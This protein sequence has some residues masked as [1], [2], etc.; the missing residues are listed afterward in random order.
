[1]YNMPF[2]A[3]HGG[4]PTRIQV[5]ETCFADHRDRTLFHHLNW[6]VSLP[7]VEIDQDNDVSFHKKSGQSSML[8][9]LKL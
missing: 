3:T 2:S 9:D 8:Q 1:M 7:N 6:Y 5:P 4:M